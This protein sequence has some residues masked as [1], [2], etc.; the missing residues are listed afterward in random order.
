MVEK[1]DHESE[2]K[3]AYKVW[4]EKRE[5]FRSSSFQLEK[6]AQRR[7]DYF[8]K[9]TEEISYKTPKMKTR[10]KVQKTEDELIY[11]ISEEAEDLSAGDKVNKELNDIENRVQKYKS[12][13]T[14]DQKEEGEY[15]E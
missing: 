10:D 7:I 8:K 4:K 2:W 12:S 15:N 11:K 14:R 3:E 1:G 9:E 5:D 13:E 6:V